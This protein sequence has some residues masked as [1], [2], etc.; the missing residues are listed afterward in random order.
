MGMVPAADVPRT[1]SPRRLIA[2]AG[3]G[4]FAEWYDFAV[5]G[6]VA[7][8]LAKQFFPAGNPAVALI[9]AY[10]LFGLT[11]VSRPLGGLFAGW[12][13]DT[14]G[15]R[16][17]LSFTVLL[18][19][20]GTML[21]G[22]IPTYSK[23]GIAAPLLLAI[24]RLIQGLGTGGEYSSAIAFV[25][26]HS[27]PRVR[28]VRISYLV[29]MTFLGI[30][31]SVLA[32]S[33]CTAIVGESVFENWGWRILFLLSG[34]LGIAGLYLRNRVAETPEFARV[35]AESEV[36]HTK[37]TPIRA[38]F[39]TQAKAMVLFFCVVSAYAL[40]TPVLSSYFITFMQSSGGISHGA[41]YWISVV[42]NLVMIGATLVAGRLMSN[43]GLQRTF[44]IGG[45]F[46]AVI[47][48]P[49]FALASHGVA[50]ALVGG[51]LLAVG[52]GIVAVAGAMAMSYMFPARVRVTAGAFAYNVCTITFGAAG[53]AIGLWLNDATGT[54]TAFSVY[55][56]V[57][58]ALSVV[59]A[60]VGRSRL[61]QPATPA[62]A[63]AGPLEY[64]H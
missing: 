46:I 11:Y 48:V 55:L 51:S 40:I 3:I 47:S 19:C 24:C 2:S 53:P 15:R 64:Q 7:S 41:S 52:K 59:A 18:M 21:I 23:I 22:F 54:S 14:L 50:G 56:A 30:T 62:P 25:Y 61:I 31:T 37:A 42:V 39:R 16:R 4:N 5:Y 38:A 36:Q 49:A 27:D 32:A 13:G 28:P 44:V 6:V 20:T 35:N 34:P 9:S 17:A 57:V 29:T 26:E 58:G 45:L 63:P 10:A 43:H 12:L 60:C 8:I 1:E 33:V